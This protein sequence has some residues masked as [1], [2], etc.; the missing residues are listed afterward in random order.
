[1]AGL[2]VGVWSDE[3]E[4]AGNWKRAGEFEPTLSPERAEEL[5]AAWNEAVRRATQ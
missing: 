4:L 3:S 2:A 1:M 5:R